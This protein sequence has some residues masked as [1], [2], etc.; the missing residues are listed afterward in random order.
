[1]LISQT[2]LR[3]E[4]CIYFVYYQVSLRAETRLNLCLL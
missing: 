1:M 3:H 2:G 4:V